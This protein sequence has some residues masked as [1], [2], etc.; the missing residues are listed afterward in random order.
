MS[1]PVFTYEEFHQQ[2]ERFARELPEMLAQNALTAD[3]APK[4]AGLLRFDEK[5]F[6]VAVVGQMRV[7]KSSLLNALVDRDDMAIT[8]VEETTATVNWFKYGEGD[9]LDKFRV[10]WK[11]KAAEEFPRAE[12]HNWIGQSEQ[13]ARTAYV[14][15]FADSPFL[16]KANLVDT[17]GTRS[18]IESHEE[19]TQSF[20]S[21][22]LEEETV[23]LG[24]SADAIIYA[25]PPVARESDEDL[26]SRFG[27]ETRISGSAA[28]NSIGVLHKWDALN[29]EDPVTIAEERAAIMSK[30]MRQGVSIVLP[31]SA[32]LHNASLKDDSLWLPLYRIATETEASD[33]KRLLR[34]E[35]RFKQ[36]EVGSC[37]L[38]A[39]ERTSLRETH[40]MPWPTLALLLRKG[41][42]QRFDS[43]DDFRAWSRKA[44]G[45]DR[46]R[47]ELNSRF[48]DRS[49]MI[50]AFSVLS[51]VR[52]PCYV[53]TTRLENEKRRADDDLKNLPAYLKIIEQA[54]LPELE[55][56]KDFL[57]RAEKDAQERAETIEVAHRMIDA[58]AMRTSEACKEMSSDADALELLDQEDNSKGIPS[59]MKDCLRQLLGANG[60][61]MEARV[62]GLA[63][64][65][66]DFGVED[67]E[68]LLEEMENLSATLSSTPATI[69][70]RAIERLDQICHHLEGQAK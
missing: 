25:F 42:S 45:V 19:A 1:D 7:G 4:V 57:E 9:L 16:K 60:P 40:P 5:L 31:A 27:D 11:D 63:R 51:K 33:L 43:P 69:V 18:A 70:T 59:A 28:Y 35:K 12:I 17:P 13:A 6:T 54:K 50:R 20:L 21:A 46:L 62:S 65:K 61:E 38:A 34:M 15:L 8:G 66:G 37:P 64:D 48:F 10:V 41:A 24:G 30:H 44:G 32:P 14:E 53:A 55:P 29:V 23:R 39:E 3:L 49:R 67:A 52:D 58:T 22:K 68:K 36:A 26:L 2:I 47:E 56:I